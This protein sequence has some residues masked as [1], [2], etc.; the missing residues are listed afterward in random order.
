MTGRMLIGAALALA[1]VPAA[2]CAYTL[3][4]MHYGDA[5]PPYDARSLALGGAGLAS[6]DGARGLA[7]NPALLGKADGVDIA[8][9]GLVIAAEEARD[10]PLHDSFDGIIA[11]NTYALNMNLYDRYIASVAL[12]PT[13]MVGDVGVPVPV[14]GIGYRPL[15][16]MS[17]HY[18]VQYRDPDTQTEPNDKILY[19]YYVDQDGGVNAFS[20]ALGQEIVPDIMAGIGVDFLQG[21]FDV[22]ERWIFP[23]DSEEDDV[24]ARAAYDN[25][26]GTRFTVGLHS[27]QFHRFDLAVVYRSGFTLEGDYSVSPTGEDTLGAG[28]TIELEYPDIWA[29]G[30]QYHPRNGV[31]TTVNL[32]VEYA[33][34][35]EFEDNT[36]DADFDDTITYRIGVEHEFYDDTQ[37]RFGFSYQPSYIDERTTRAAFSAGLGLKV[38]GVP[39]DIGGQVGLREYD[40]DEGRVR[41]TTTMVMVT[42]VHSF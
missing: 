22:Q 14:I 6:A 24:D 8:F 10:I 40:I 1:L 17:Y 12:D 3:A 5:M 23:P 30:V 37:A 41:E 19:D 16:D 7:V 32:D 9:T 38:L 2:A 39:V 33:R 34:W 35:S 13:M 42:V 26:G 29:F 27:E 15:L 11:D 4:E 21:D 18:H 31:L 28:G 36:R 20:V 25:L